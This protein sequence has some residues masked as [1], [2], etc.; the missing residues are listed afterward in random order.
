M[1][2]MVIHN[3]YGSEAPSGENAAVD[4]EI[5][6]L[7]S[8]GVDVSAFTRSSD[9]IRRSGVFG[10]A[11][12]GVSW[13]RNPVACRAARR[14]A[15]AFAPDV[16]HVHNT[17]P[18]LSNDVFAALRGVAPRV[19]TVHNYRLVCP[20]A[21]PMRDGV[22]C[23]VCIDR[24]SGWPGVYHACYRNSALAT[25]PLALRASYDRIRGTWA[26]DVDAFIVFS[27]FQRRLLGEAGLPRTRM[28][29][30][31]NPYYGSPQPLPWQARENRVVFAGRVAAEKGVNDL[32]DAWRLGGNRTPHLRVV[33]DGPMLAEME[34]AARD[35]PIEFLGSVSKETARREISQAK[36][37]VVPSRW[38]E[39]FPLVISEALAHGTPLAVADIGPLGEIVEDANAGEKF[40]VGNAE[41]LW[42][43]VNRMWNDESLLRHY[44]ANAIA[45]YHR[46]YT[47]DAAFTRLLEIYRQAGVQGSG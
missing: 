13:L 43:V 20:A 7:R 5:A 30:R 37:L 27:D 34:Q 21:I 46:S 35:L 15:M 11:A 22:A 40:L 24:R 23:T 14:Q 9:G 28:H 26:R 41:S 25:I 1:R 19:L 16:I 8:R 42:D 29:V 38:F 39:G 47:D 44:S 3:Y 12:G 2:V 32:V 31:P 36:L 17:F 45:S 18:L 4:A 33:G 6:L 10:A